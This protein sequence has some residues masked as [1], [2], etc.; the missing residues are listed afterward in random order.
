MQCLVA[1]LVLRPVIVT[2]ANRKFHPI[3]EF[4]IRTF[5]NLGHLAFSKIL[6]IEAVGSSPFRIK[7]LSIDR[8]DEQATFYDFRQWNTGV[9]IITSGVQTEVIHV[10]MGLDQFDQARQRDR[11][12]L[13]P[14]NQ[15]SDVRTLPVGLEIPHLVP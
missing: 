12:P 5:V 14:W 6:D 1:F 13:S 15:W 3:Q 7:G 9:E 11:F 10:G 8:M 4:N 2:L